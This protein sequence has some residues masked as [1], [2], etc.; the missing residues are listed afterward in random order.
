MRQSTYKF[1]AYLIKALIACVVSFLLGIL[2]VG[3]ECLGPSYSSYCPRYSVKLKDLDKTFSGQ[4]LT[5]TVL[6]KT[7]SFS[8]S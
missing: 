2:T 5:C 6:T 7:K 1:F 8:V 4:T 3:F